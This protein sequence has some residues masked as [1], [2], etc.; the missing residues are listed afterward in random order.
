VAVLE[1]QD[2][3]TLTPADLNHFRN[4][5]VHKNKKGAKESATSVKVMKELGYNPKRKK[6]ASSSSSSVASTRL[7]KKEQQ[8]SKK[9]SASTCAMAAAPEYHALSLTEIQRLA[10]ALDL[11]VDA[12]SVPAP[13]PVPHGSGRASVASA[14]PLE[15]RCIRMVTAAVQDQQGAS[16]DIISLVSENVQEALESWAQGAPASASA[17][18][19]STSLSSGSAGLLVHAGVPV[20]SF[21][22]SPSSS[23][24]DQICL[25]ADGVAS[26]LPWMHGSS[27][28]RLSGTDFRA[29]ARL[30]CAV[31]LDEV[32]LSSGEGVVE[33]LLQQ[34]EEE[35]MMEVGVLC[36][37]QVVWFASLFSVEVKIPGHRRPSS[38][39]AGVCECLRL[40]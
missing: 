24:P 20:A 33:K 12:L 6:T 16:L 18:A 15:S 39:F 9:E 1:L 35:T 13:E 17:A 25:L 10:G 38:L 37:E 7:T 40:R 22:P 32:A 28:A 11:N 23:S 21:L 31:T 36:T 34:V 26:L 29:L 4:K 2:P 14:S 5:V 30:R 27:T 8:A 19:T 3:L